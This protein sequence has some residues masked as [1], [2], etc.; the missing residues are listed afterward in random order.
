MATTPAESQ[1]TR[2]KNFAN[3]FKGYMGVMPIVTAAL[4]PLVTA[5]KVIDS[6]AIQTKPLTAMT[7]IFGFLLLGWIFYIRRTIALG[8]MTKGF[9]WIMN[10]VPLGM[11][12]GSIVCF[13]SYTDLLDTSLAQARKDAPAGQQEERSQL[14]SHTGQNGAIP[15]GNGLILLY[16]GVFLC[17][18]GAFIMMALREYTIDV[19]KLSEYNWIFDDQQ[20]SM[21][22]LELKNKID[23]GAA[24]TNEPLQARTQEGTV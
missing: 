15:Y 1:Q 20:G 19:L 11:I 2:I 18:E 23:S 9:R 7:G 3:V 10:I 24:Q 17:A 21:S 12:L 4:A 8:S 16:E 6:Y 5:T 14:L 13:V 22:P